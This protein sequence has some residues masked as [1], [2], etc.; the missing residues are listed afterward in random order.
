MASYVDPRREATIREIHSLVWS[1]YAGDAKRGL[2][3]ARDAFGESDMSMDRARREMDLQVR[4]LNETRRA[5]EFKVPS[6]ALEITRAQVES[7]MKI[8]AARPSKDELLSTK[9]AQLSDRGSEVEDRWKI[10]YDLRTDEGRKGFKEA[11][12]AM[13]PAIELE[14]EQA[15]G[16]QSKAS[17]FVRDRV[18]G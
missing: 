8:Q 14:T 15:Q 9:G 17:E 13:K 10:S 4:H 12:E 1:H 5:E 3:L 16:F 7:Q 11:C 2:K 6:G 18:N